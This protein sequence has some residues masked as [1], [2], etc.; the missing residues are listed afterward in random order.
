M[1]LI[2]I[3]AALVEVFASPAFAHTGVGQT[4]SF[5]SGMLHPFGGADHVVAMASVGIWGVIVGGRAIWIWPAAFMAAMLGG[6]A[7]AIL[8]L[9]VS[10]V[11]PA[12]AS[13]I[14]ILGLL[15]ALGVKAPLSVGAAIVGLF[16]FFHGHAHGTEA[17]A[18][19]LLPYLAGFVLATASLHAA[20]I[21]VGL[22]VR[23]L[24]K[25]IAFACAR[26]VRGASQ[27]HFDGRLT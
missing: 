6:F 27:R 23:S 20:G 5:A 7:A 4:Y 14:A 15:V 16:A 18:V 1:R 13:S 3:C 8:G 24:A 19:T 25:K 2:L 21:G 12:I 9:Q 10:F 11:E 17:G 26:P 22:C